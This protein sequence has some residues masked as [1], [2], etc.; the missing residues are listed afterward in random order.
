M[1]RLEAHNL[2]HPGSPTGRTPSCPRPG[3]GS[4]GDPHRV[5]FFGA[6]RL[7]NSPLFCE[8]LGASVRVVIRVG[9]ALIS[10]KIHDWLSGATATATGRE[11][12]DEGYL[13][14][15]TTVVRVHQGP[16]GATRHDQSYLADEYVHAP[17]G[18]FGAWGGECAVWGVGVASVQCGVGSAVWGAGSAGALVG[19][20]GARLGASI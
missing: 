18:A 10:A 8:A 5:L 20:L 14:G 7:F 11:G 1:A 13:R 12:S 15:H 16:P 3:E 17:V 9:G 2:P 4:D 19:A 6:D